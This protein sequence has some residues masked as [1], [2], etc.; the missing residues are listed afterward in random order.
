MA[1][2]TDDSILAVILLPCF[3]FAYLGQ[4]ENMDNKL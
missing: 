4:T 3:I 2:G 1:H